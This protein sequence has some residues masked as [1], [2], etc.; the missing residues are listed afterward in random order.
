MNMFEEVMKIKIRPVEAAGEKA[1]A[2]LNL[3]TKIHTLLEHSLNSNKLSAETIA[4]FILKGMCPKCDQHEDCKSYQM[5]DVVKP[6]MDKIMAD[7]EL[8]N[9][10]QRAIE[11][12][13]FEAY[14]R[15]LFTNEELETIMTDMVCPICNHNAGCTVSW[16]AL[17]NPKHLAEEEK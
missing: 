15:G 7:E 14:D 5:S 16:N 3:R 8:A 10:V 2:S 11:L 17:C 6:V 13:F 4:W 12:F 9:L 1:W